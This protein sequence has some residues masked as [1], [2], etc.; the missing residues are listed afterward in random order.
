MKITNLT[1]YVVPRPADGHWIFVRVDTDD[2]LT[3]WG[4]SGGNAA[5]TAESV[6]AALLDLR[7]DLIGRDPSDIDPIWHAI[8][9][10]Y[11][12]F[13]SRGFG[14][15][16]AAGIDIA[17]WDIKGQAAG[18]PVYDL[19]GGRF[20]DRIALYSNSWF[21]GAAP[22]PEAYAAAAREKLAPLGHTA[23]KLD[24]FFEMRPFHRRYESGQISEA[25]EQL[26]YDVVAAVREVVGPRFEI[27][28]DAHGHY[29]VPTA[30]RLANTLYE[31][32][33]IAWFE[34]PVP[35]ES[36]DALRAVREHTS[37]AIA[38]GERLR[39]RWD[40]LPVLQN[41]LADYLMP[42]TVWT[43]GISEAKKIASLAEVFNVPIS[44]HVVPMGPLELIAAGH[45]VTSI[46]NF[47]RLE[48]S[49]P[50]IEAHARLLNEPYQIQEGH[51]I[52]NGKPGLGYALDET[53]L[54]GHDVSNA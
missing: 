28:I 32:S 10:R 4:E 13:G 25:G 12:Y 8:Y 14:T 35:P 23:C 36:V 45:V 42:D 21:N 50:L 24:P 20:R 3:G 11:T 29:N 19:L 51:L 48:H 37:C 33:R 53:W 38:V 52:L 16:V 30:I 7:A 43:G 44:P 9:R 47:Y 26:G 40:F 39:T 31:R 1:P 6:R 22:T 34:E 54:R 46:P 15:A 18:K 41:R 17:L 5:G 27:L 49:H 2:G